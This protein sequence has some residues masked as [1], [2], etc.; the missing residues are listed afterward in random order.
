M[1]LMAGTYTVASATGYPPEEV[2][3]IVIVTGPGTTQDFNLEMPQG[4][5]TPDQATHLEYNR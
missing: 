1:T 2:P 5:W 4:A 3:G